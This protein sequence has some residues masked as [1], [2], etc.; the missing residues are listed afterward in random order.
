MIIDTILER[1]GFKRSERKSLELL[2]QMEEGIEERKPARRV[3]R[4][5]K[6]KK[7]TRKTVKKKIE[8]KGRKRKGEKR[9]KREM[10]VEYLKKRKK[11][12][13]IEDIAKKVGA[14]VQ[15]TRRYLYYLAKEGKVRK[16]K[17]GW[18]AR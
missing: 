9:T 2:R 1:L 6:E 3:R 16:V 11:P 5:R 17:E 7:K 18:V 4:E 14:T 15:T 8:K 10:I 13:K 12:A